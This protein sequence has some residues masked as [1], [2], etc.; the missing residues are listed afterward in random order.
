[1]DAILGLVAPLWEW[2]AG[3]AVALFGMWFARREIRRGRENEI[4]VRDAQNAQIIRDRVARDLD[5]RVRE[6]DD[7]GYRD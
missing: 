7:S 3:G 5:Q 2:L 4:R 1:M 6:H